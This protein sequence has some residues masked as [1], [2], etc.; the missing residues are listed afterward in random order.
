MAMDLKQS[1][2]NSLPKSKL[3]ARRSKLHMKDGSQ[4]DLVINLKITRTESNIIYCISC[5]KQSGACAKVYPQY[6]Y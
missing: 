2:H 1:I 6:V 4:E 5:S 3:P